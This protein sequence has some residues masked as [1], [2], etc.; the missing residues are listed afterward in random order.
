[1]AIANAV[2]DSFKT[3]LM[4]GMHNFT[5]QSLTITSVASGTGV[6][7]YSAAG[8]ASNAYA[9]YLFTMAGYGTAANNGTFLCTASTSTT[10][11]TTN[12]SSV[13]SGTMG[14]TVSADTFYIALYTSSRTTLDKTTTVYDTTNEMANTGGSAYTAGGLAL[15]GVTPTLSTDTACWVPSSA[16]WN[17]ATFTCRGA[18]VYNHSKIINAATASPADAL[19]IMNISSGT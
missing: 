13:N 18:L 6:Y 3:Q 5:N 4:Q 11:T 15:T 7:T 2:C 19:L 10:I 16:V 12:T 1:M 17:T 14:T 9:G 8:G